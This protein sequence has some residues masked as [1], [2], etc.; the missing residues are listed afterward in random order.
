MVIRRGACGADLNDVFRKPRCKTWER[1][2]ILL[3]LAILAPTPT[4]DVRASKQ[5]KQT[6]FGYALSNRNYNNRVSITHSTGLLK[7]GM[8]IYCFG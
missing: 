1:V 4:I 7:K 5:R 8:G 6:S 2:T 3:V